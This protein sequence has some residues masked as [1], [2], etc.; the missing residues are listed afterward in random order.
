MSSG[1]LF[2]SA[3]IDVRRNKESNTKTRKKER[4]TGEIL[5]IKKVSMKTVESDAE[6]TQQLQQVSH[7]ERF[8]SRTIMSILTNQFLSIKWK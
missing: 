4:V 1:G 3:C 6:D 7:R 8:L 2:S 5:N